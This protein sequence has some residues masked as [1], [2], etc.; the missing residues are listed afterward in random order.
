MINTKALYQLSDLVKIDIPEKEANSML[1]EFNKTIS[2]VNTLH[3][4]DTKDVE[5]LAILS[6]ENNNMQE[7]IT[8]ESLPLHGVF[9]NSPT[10]DNNYFKVPDIK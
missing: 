5:P 10:A 1:L 3:K 6:F 9:K 7:D 8:T 4:L 2:W